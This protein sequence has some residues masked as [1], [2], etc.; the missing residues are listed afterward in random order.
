MHALR[1][2]SNTQHNY[3]NWSSLF[4]TKHS[5]VADSCDWSRAYTHRIPLA[6]LWREPLQRC[7]DE[8]RQRMAGVGRRSRAAPPGGTPAGRRAQAALSSAELAGAVS[9]SG[10]RRSVRLGGRPARPGAVRTGLC[11]RVRP[12]AA[13][14]AAPVR[15]DGV[16]GD[17]PCAGGRRRRTARQF[18]GAWGAGVAGCGHAGPACGHGV[19]V[20]TPGGRRGTGRSGRDWRLRRRPLT[21]SSL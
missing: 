8:L 2:T 21:R 16:I 14:G 19:S 15:T 3:K 7:G 12:T 18:P 13:S 9:L 6:E 10:A 1:Y 4:N 20:G 5:T 17:K 11:R